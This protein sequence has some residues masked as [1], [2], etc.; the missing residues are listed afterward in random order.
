[1]AQLATA[2]IGD[3]GGDA[4]LFHFRRR[5]DQE[6]P[7][8]PYLNRFS[9]LSAS[10]SIYATG[11]RQLD[12]LGEFLHYYRV[13]ENADGKNGKQELARVLPLLWTHPFGRLPAQ[14]WHH[15]SAAFKADLLARWKRRAVARLAYLARRSINVADH[16]YSRGRCGI[17]HGKTG[18]RTLDAG[19]D[20]IEIACDVPLVKMLARVSIDSRIPP[21]HTRKPEDDGW[22]DVRRG[23]KRAQVHENDR[24][25]VDIVIPYT[26]PPRE[27][28]SS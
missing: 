22:D 25:V 7:D 12:P 1:M 9:A 16:L 3:G 19:S 4:I 26:A 21:V 13:L 27:S 5:G 11:L 17:A 28:P 18:I 10:L 20:L 2:R 24:G 23:I 14:L 15:H 8:L 6:W